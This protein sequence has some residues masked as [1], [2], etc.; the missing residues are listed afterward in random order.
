[1]NLARRLAAL[2]FQRCPRCCRGGIFSGSFA[3]NERCPSCQLRF[4]REPG[5][6][7]GAMY[8]SYGMGVVIITLAAALLSAAFP[9]WSNWRTV[10]AAGLAF[11]P[12]VPL[13]FRWSRAMWMYFDYA[14]NPEF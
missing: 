1:V 9:E 14:L 3:M 6:F 7:L 12:F 5:Y 13:V 11:L 8:F 2:L 10:F 4:Q